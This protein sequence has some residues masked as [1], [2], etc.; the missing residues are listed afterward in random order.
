MPAR[1]K[2]GQKQRGIIFG[3]PHFAGFYLNCDA[4]ATL[5]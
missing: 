2:N 3:A 1:M 5:A 4:S